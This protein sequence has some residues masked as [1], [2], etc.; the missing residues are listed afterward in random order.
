[1]ADCEPAELQ[2]LIDRGRAPIILDVRSGAEFAAGHIAGAVHIPFWAMPWRTGALAAAPDAAIVVY[3][4]HGPRA[5]F[6]R[7]MLRRRGFTRVA[8]LAGHM[9]GWRRAG[10]PE[11]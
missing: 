1:M 2:E 7:A 4:G 3:C 10:L 8:L 6:A 5:Q 9:T 11:A